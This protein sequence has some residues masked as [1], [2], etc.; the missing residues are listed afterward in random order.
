MHDVTR[1]IVYFSSSANSTKAIKRVNTIV[2]KPGIYLFTAVD[3]NL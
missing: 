3:L 1:A 2:L